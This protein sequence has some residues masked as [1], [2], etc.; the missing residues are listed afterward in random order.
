MA[1]SSLR[2]AFTI[3]ALVLLAGFAGTT[4]AYAYIDGGSASLL[5][6][7]LIAGVLGTLFAIRGQLYRF[8]S[9]LVSLV[10][11]LPRADTTGDE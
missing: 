8:K 11:R 4:P 6:Q 9:Y 7:L 3:F 2:R 1:G 5:F 10:R